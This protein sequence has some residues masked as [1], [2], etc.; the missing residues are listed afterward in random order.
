M[1]KKR[2]LAVLL[3]AVMIV[4]I[5]PAGAGAADR[6]GAYGFTEERSLKR[7][8]GT[9]HLLRHTASDAQVLWLENEE[10][11][12]SFAAG[13]RTPP[14]DS[15]GENHVLEH[16]LLCGS[17]KYPVRELMHVLANT[18][19]ADELNAYTSD[20]YTC[21]VVRTKNETDFYNLSDVYMSSVLFPQL[22]TE[23][24]IFKQQGIRL[25]YVDGKAQYNGIVFSE[26]KLRS[27]D[28]D[29]NSLDFVGDQ[30]YRNLYGNGTPTLD[31]GGAIPDIFNLTYDDVMRVYNTYYKPSNMLIYVAGKQDIGKTLQMLGGYLSKAD[32]GSVPKITFDNKPLAQTKTVQEYNLT[33][34]TK[35][36]D[37]GFMTHGPDVLDLKNTEALNALA[38]Y[39]QKA[40]QEQFPDTLAYTIGGMGGGISN[41]GIIL[42]EVPVAQK[43][44]AV[45]A[46]QKLLDQAAQNGVPAEKLNKLLDQQKEWQQFGREEIFY[47]FA[48]ENDPLACIGRMDAIDALKND[49]QT[50]QKLAAGWRDSPYQTVV[51]AGNGGAKPVIPEPKL[52]D[53]ELQQ[54]KRDT[55]AFNAWI[56]TPD[57]P[58]D[59][60][61]LPQLSPKDFSS[62]PFDQELKNETSPEAT[63]FHTVDADAEQAEFSF[64]F[65]IEAK[66]DDLAAWCLLAEFLNDQMEKGGLSSYLGMDGGA[67][68]IDPNILSPAL[69]IGGSAAPQELKTQVESLQKLLGAPP[70]QDA[71]ALRDFLTERKRQL[72]I[73]F[74]NPYQTEYGLKLLAGSQGNRFLNNAPTGFVGSSRSYQ[75]FLEKAANSPENDGALLARLR[76]LLDTALTRGGIAVNFTGGEADYHTFQT[77]AKP[78]LAAL[79]EGGGVSSCEFLP[80][81]WPSALVVATGTQDGNHVMIDGVYEEPVDLATLRVLGSVLGSK[82]M[83]PELRDKRGAYGANV[84]FDQDGMTMACA[85]GVPVD[86]VIAVFK[87]VGAYVRGLTLTESELN[88]YI[89]GALKEYDEEAEWSRGNGAALARTGKTQADFDRER[90]ALMAV[91]LN[92]LRACADLLDRMTAQNRVFAQVNAAE[93]AKIQFPFACR[94]DADTGRVRPMLRADL[95]QNGAKTPLTRK[96]AAELLAES[97]IDQTAVERPELPRFTDASSDALSRLHDR[98]LLH[99]YA[100]GSFHP[101]APITRAE[102]C[103]IADAL[104]PSGPADGPS[105]SDVG[106][107]HWAHTVISRMAG[108]GYLKGDPEGTFRPEDTITGAEA[109]AILRRISAS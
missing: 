108:L 55:E 13:F 84:R 37:I 18:S 31:S 7:E 72:R 67:Q 43:D 75:A 61:K 100:D 82:Y 10:E 70:L 107:G 36:V 93:A 26:L 30:M 45:Q 103:V 102:F 47:G 15:M 56:G 105:F 46:F 3:C 6:F 86:E 109:L 27:L 74:S 57:S 23:P 66:A 96:Q 39:L 16:A 76:G 11:E 38:T 73:N 87:G 8:E 90:A 85:G 32:R 9:Y 40:L 44:Q 60:A 71:A 65:P 58:E 104:A 99:G 21:Y 12:R 1:M 64:Y 83:L 28:T 22:R 69:I 33:A 98:G 77:A 48:Y 17:E 19:V 53:A 29:E 54:V 92:D 5:L 97:L 4:S 88:G 80:G 59:I 35:T 24:N 52:T 49:R 62:S 81:F 25:E 42:S 78:F 50:F 20:D 79:P 34:S 63:W 68:Y 101:D 95:P 14:Q 51:I 106:G 2:M 94:A 41:V 91:T 89:I